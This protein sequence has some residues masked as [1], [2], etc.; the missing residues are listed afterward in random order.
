MSPGGARFDKHGK[1]LPDSGHGCG[2]QI[3]ADAYA[4][5]VRQTRPLAVV[6]RRIAGLIDRL[7]SDHRPQTV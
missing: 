7:A 1:A 3:C 6:R 4:E 5:K 2:C